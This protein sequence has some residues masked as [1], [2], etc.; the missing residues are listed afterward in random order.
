MI[1]SIQLPKCLRLTVLAVACITWAIPTKGQIAFRVFADPHPTVAGGTIGFAFA[2]NKF[3]GSSQG[4]GAGILYST[5][6]AGGN[7]QPF[8]PQ[9][10]VRGGN[11]YSEHC[12]ASSLGLGGFP[13]RDI[14]V[15]A[16]NGVLHI[17]NDGTQSDMLV[18]GLSGPVDAILFDSIGTFGHQMLVSTE[19]G[20]I[21]RVDSTGTASLIAS[22]GIR[23]EAMDIAPVGAGF[24]PYDG[25]LIV[26]SE[27]E[28][29]LRAI[30][31]IGT[32]SILNPGNPIPDIE[33]LHFVPLD[34][35][36]SGSPVEGFYSANFPTNILKADASQFRAFR[37]DAILQTELLDQRISRVHW[38]GQ[39]FEITIIGYAP[40][41]GEDALFVTPHMI[42]PGN[43]PCPPDTGSANGTNNRGQ[44]PKRPSPPRHNP[45]PSL[46]RDRFG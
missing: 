10:V 13:K 2:G 25:H 19:E 7:T 37:G 16:G 39:S 29:L 14:Y 6:L 17:S 42:D 22:I 21:Y 36:A 20:K 44:A 33:S 35:G 41:Q 38:N 28:G 27:Y 45:R 12:V 4:D 31:S 30:S 43:P 23:S 32:V 24:G 18:D 9:V 40:G 26:I 3:V 34:L 15:S 8:A 11:P 5:D 46:Q 1:K